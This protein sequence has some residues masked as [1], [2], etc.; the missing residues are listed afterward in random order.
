[1]HISATNYTSLTLSAGMTFFGT[2]PNRPPKLTN[3]CFFEKNVMDRQIGEATKKQ[4]R[5]AQT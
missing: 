4:Q 1:M 3:F 2:H 5:E